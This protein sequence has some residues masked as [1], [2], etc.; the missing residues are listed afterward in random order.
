MF[1]FLSCPS[2]RHNTNVCKEKIALP[3]CNLLSL[4]LGQ[5]NF[6]LVKQAY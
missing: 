5:I 3:A 2:G 6:L 4:L 1:V